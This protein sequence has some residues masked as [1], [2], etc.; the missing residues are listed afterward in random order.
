MAVVRSVPLN[1]EVR[2][3]L[4]VDAALEIAC[5]AALLGWRGDLQHWLG[6]NEIAVFV[7]AAV[8]FLAAIGPLALVFTPGAAPA[9]GPLAWGNAIG[10]AAGWVAFP[11]L[12]SWF[13][14]EGRWVAAA[15]FDAFIAVGVAELIALRRAR[16][17]PR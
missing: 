11:F 13:E 9:I 1:G 3:L 7:L 16:P 8:F 15:V 5:A 12:W 2:A 10:G 14:P 6:L 17:A 4:L